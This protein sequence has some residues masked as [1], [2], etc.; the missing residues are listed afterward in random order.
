MKDSRR[1]AQ[2]VRVQEKGQVTL[3]AEVR[4][5]LG[6]KKGDLV[7]VTQTPEGVLITPQEVIAMQALDRLGE[8]LSKRGLSLEELI[9]S[10]R[11][12]RGEFIKEQYGIV[13]EKQ[14]D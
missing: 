5:N 14:D 9:E 4:R 8:A 2:L 6:L 1:G 3:P 10:G 13:P 7:A 11:D 12:I